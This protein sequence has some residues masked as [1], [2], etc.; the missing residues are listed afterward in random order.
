[1]GIF[2]KLPIK[3]SQNRSSARNGLIPSLSKVYG[4]IK[5]RAIEKMKRMKKYMRNKIYWMGE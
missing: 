3:E 5:I 1:M 2:I 4:I